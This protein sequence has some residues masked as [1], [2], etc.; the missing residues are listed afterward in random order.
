MSGPAAAWTHSIT[1]RKRQTVAPIAGPT[2]ALQENLPLSARKGVFS[3]DKSLSWMTRFADPTRF[4]RF[5]PFCQRYL[6][7]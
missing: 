7:V 6:P 5:A 1:D 2:T 4:A 3:L